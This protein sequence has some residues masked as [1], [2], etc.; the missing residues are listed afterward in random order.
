M[1]TQ[2]RVN[3]ALFG[4]TEL[5]SEKVELSLVDDF[6]KSF[7]KANDGGEK[8]SLDLI[9]SLRKAEV[10]YEQNISKWRDALKISE[11]LEQG[12]KDLGM[13]LPSDVKNKIASCKV[14]IKE[15][16]AYISN[17]KGFY[18]KF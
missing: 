2:E 3:Q 9:D 18:S 11:K 4:K 14:S 6:Q 10:K 16:E 17:I 1:N 7:D 8:V 5:K 15:E 13:D 12:F